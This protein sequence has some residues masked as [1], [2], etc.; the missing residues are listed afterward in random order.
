MANSI[1]RRSHSLQVS[2]PSALLAGQNSSDIVAALL[3]AGAD[4]NQSSPPWGLPLIEAAFNGRARMVESL[5][6]HGANPNIQ[7]NNGE[8]PLSGA[9]DRATI[10][11]GNWLNGNVT[12][13]GE[14]KAAFREI[15]ELLQQHGADEFLQR[16]G[17]ISAVRGPQQRVDIFSKGTNDLNRYTLMEF[18]AAVY[19]NGGKD[20]PFPDFAKIT[21]HRVN[22]T[23]AKVP[24]D[25]NGQF[26]VNAVGYV[27]TKQPI[28]VDAAKLLTK[29]ND[30]S[31]DMPLEWGDYVEIPMADHPVSSGWYGIPGSEHITLAHCA[32][33]Q[34]KFSAGG[35]N[36]SFTLW[37]PERDF[38]TPTPGRRWP[39]FRLSN[40]V[41]HD[42]RFRNLLRSSSDLSR[43]RVT[44]TDPQT[45]ESKKM[46]FDLNAVALPDM[47]Y[48][49]NPPP[50]PWAH[51]LWLREGDVIE[52]PE[53][54]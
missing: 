37:L 6:K 43:V 27:T 8:T 30:C 41:L 11:A 40:V 10:S 23:V 4:A 22:P 54:P 25:P 46:T 34:V 20:F 45:K 14:L 5:L 53:K 42:A 18:L 33:R 39:F 15:V 38:N 24:S 26:S 44:R 2:V 52:V 19:E 48:S 49:G 50:I 28:L 29:T 13:T 47:S 3:E 9:R 21:I 35:T 7:I 31:G 16:R 12:M 1:L 17:F 51:D 36:V 32:Q